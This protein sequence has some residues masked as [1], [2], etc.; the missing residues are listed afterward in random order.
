MR[1][2]LKIKFVEERETYTKKIVEHYE[3]QNEHL[4]LLKEI[5]NQKYGKDSAQ[6]LIREYLNEKKQLMKIESEKILYSNLKNDE[7][8]DKKQYIEKR[9]TETQTETKEYSDKSIETINIHRKTESIQTLLNGKEIEENLNSLST[10]TSKVKS[11]ELAHASSMNELSD[12][13]EDYN[14]KQSELKTQMENKM[15]LI[16]NEYKELK[17][18]KSN[19][20]NE[21]DF[22]SNNYDK[23]RKECESITSSNEKLCE[24]KNLNEK[25]LSENKKSMELLSEELK[26]K[27]EE[28]KNIQNEYEE[29][30]KSQEAELETKIKEINDLNNKILNLD[31]GIRMQKIKETSLTEEIDIW[32][33]NEK[34]LKETYGDLHYSL[35]IAQEE[36][37]KLQYKL[38]ESDKKCKNYETKIK[39]LQS[40]L[41][42]IVEN[43]ETEVNSSILMTDSIIEEK[44][45][46]NNIKISILEEIN[47]SYR[48]IQLEKVNTKSINLKEKIEKT[49]KSQELFENERLKKLLQKS[50]AYEEQMN[51]Y[52][53]NYTPPHPPERKRD[54]R[55]ASSI[56]TIESIDDESNYNGMSRN[57]EIRNHRSSSKT[58]IKNYP[59]K[60]N[61]LDYENHKNNTSNNNGNNNNNN[62]NN[63]NTNSS[64][65]ENYFIKPSNSGNSNLSKNIVNNSNSNNHDNINISNKNKNH[66]PTLSKENDPKNTNNKIF[67]NAPK[68]NTKFNN[69]YPTTYTSSIKMAEIIYKNFPRPNNKFNTSNDNNK[70]KNN[71]SGSNKTPMIQKTT[72]LTSNNKTHSQNSTNVKT[73][74]DIQTKYPPTKL[75]KYMIPSNIIKDS[76]NKSSHVSIFNF[77][78]EPLESNKKPNDTKITKSSTTKHLSFSD[79]TNSI[80]SK[81]KK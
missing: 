58:S 71:V 63:N 36:I 7:L 59:N 57:D 32:K 27:I 34:K 33:E 16:Q 42:T 78:I 41:Y 37:I 5:I 53:N 17:N 38:E 70:L 18:S 24:W 43:P 56:I 77:N 4:Q 21:L 23:L 64:Y 80:Y 39:D 61:S 69:I 60:I 3:S 12:L 75:S 76:I 55:S 29:Y 2:I 30:K 79:T 6:S 22:L 11:L 81:R 65:T 52:L 54:I 35:L 13:K 31:Q 20:E 44:I 49:R 67:W 19:L 73:L 48:K 47:D 66:F 62:N 8:F 46:A 14:K 15:A 9:E 68:K 25:T 10:M 40:Q 1:I 74:N 28:I 72:S 45:A 26:Q 51:N 50:K